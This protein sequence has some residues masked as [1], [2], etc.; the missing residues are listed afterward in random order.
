MGIRLPIFQDENK[1][2]MLQQTNWAS[3]INPVL[4]NPLTNGIFLKN[5]SLVGGANVINHLL[6]RQQQGWTITDIDSAVTIYR[7][8]PLNDKT[9]TLTSSGTALVTIYVF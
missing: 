1:N 2:F 5:V 9:L 7:S 4:V 8:Q 3:A 6:S